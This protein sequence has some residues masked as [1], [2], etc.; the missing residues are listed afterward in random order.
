MIHFYS[1]QT[2]FLLK[3]KIKLKKFI[4]SQL[5][6]GKNSIKQLDF[7]FCNNKYL[8]KMNQQ[9]LQHNYFTDIIT[10]DLSEKKNII[11]AEIYIS[12]EMVNYNAR[13]LKIKKTDELLRV[14]F[15]GLLHLLGYKDK[16][17]KH[18]LQMTAMEDK[19]LLEYNNF[20]I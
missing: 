14:I 15:H 17:E 2:P 8:L 16:T 6:Q 11:E 4:I 1:L 20:I 9:F 13:Q 18:K 5:L 7:I 12:L 10:F 3:D 19:W